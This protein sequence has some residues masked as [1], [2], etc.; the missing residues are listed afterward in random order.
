[1]GKFYA[2]VLGG[3]V[4]QITIGENIIYARC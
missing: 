2:P 4:C 3:G 1:V